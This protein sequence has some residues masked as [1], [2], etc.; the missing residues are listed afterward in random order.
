MEYKKYIVYQAIKRGRQRQQIRENRFR[1]LQELEIKNAKKIQIDNLQEEMMVNGIRNKFALYDWLGRH[2]KLLY[3]KRVRIYAQYRDENG[4]LRE[5]SKAIENFRMSEVHDGSYIFRITSDEEYPFNKVVVIIGGR[6]RR[7]N[8]RKVI[9]QV[10]RIGITN[11]L[12]TPMKNR[13]IKK[14][15]T[16]PSKT[17]KERYNALVNKVIRYEKKYEDGV[18][19]ED[20]QELANNL[21]LT[22]EITNPLLI[23]NTK[24]I[25]PT[26]GIKALNRFKFLNTRPNHVDCVEGLSL[27]YSDDTLEVSSD[28]IDELYEEIKTRGIFYHI[29]KYQG[30]LTNLGT[31]TDSYRIENPFLD[32]MNKFCEE[33]D[34]H[35][36]L[37]H[38]KDK[39]ISHFL[40]N[41]D[42][43]NMGAT[44]NHNFT[45]GVF[46]HIDMEK[47]YTQ[48]KYFRNYDED[49]NII[50]EELNP[51]YMGFLNRIYELRKTDR[52]YGVGVYEVK[53]LC[54]GELETLNKIMKIYDTSCRSMILSSPELKFIRDMGGSYEIKSGC[55]GETIDINFDKWTFEKYENTPIYSR[56]IG[57]L[58]LKPNSTEVIVKSYEGFKDIIENDDIQGSIDTI[59]EVDGEIR[60]RYRN[61]GG[62]HATQI[63]LFVQAYQRIRVLQQLLEM[64]RE[65]IISVI[66]DGIYYKDHKFK[67]LAPFRFQKKEKLPTT[68][69]RQFVPI[70]FPKN[71]YKSCGLVN[72]ITDDNYRVEHWAGAGGTGKT[73]TALNNIE[74][75]GNFIRIAYI[76]ETNR[77]KKSKKNEFKG[78]DA[79]TT[80]HVLGFVGEK[81]PR[82]FSKINRIRHFYNVLLFDEVS[83]MTNEKKNKII[84]LY[85]KHKIIFA[86]DVGFQVESVDRGTEFNINENIDKIH[87][88]TK[89]YRF[90]EGD[91]IN[92]V[93]QELRNSIEHDRK[94]KFNNKYIIDKSLFNVLTRKEFLENNHYQAKDLI[95]A[96]ENR[97]AKLYDEPFKNM[98]K[99]YMKEKNKRYEKGEIIITEDKPCSSINCILRHGYTIHSIQGETAKNKL[100]IDMDKLDTQKR[101]L[102]TALSRVRRISQI[103]LIMN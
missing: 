56:I 98:K 64:K 79:Y 8:A 11:C 46:K 62:F 34:I 75:G 31:L 9:N 36:N 59:D 89:S 90:D 23:E 32:F 33:N 21:K 28:R 22:I 39:D 76:T 100:F 37:H 12:L 57:L 72:P 7:L 41:G 96:W 38:V 3:G 87:I 43:C 2:E 103:Y 1:L 70:K 49:G 25:K 45:K 88:F 101:I 63:P 68:K 17:T 99:W 40:R 51:Y 24:T 26:E 102:Y 4:V 73:Y 15:D 67:I 77:L 5:R 65:N 94:I 47:A 13:F 54:V 55:W 84:E 48:N 30:K 35:K 86:G 20:L 95:I 53:N 74:N 10:F 69:F 18:P 27:L 91:P 29:R 60:I 93:L 44:F 97:T 14:R 19:N 61:N 42:L 16:A 80:A 78:L 6:R 85:P 50:R 71:Y 92:N 81:K 58:H 66:T 82:D 52:E 83:M